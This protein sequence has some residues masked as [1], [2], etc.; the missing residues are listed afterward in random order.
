MKNY[1]KISSEIKK[2]AERYAVQLRSTQEEIA[3]LVMEI[4]DLEDRQ[5]SQINRKISDIIS[6][7]AAQTQFEGGD[8]DVNLS[9]N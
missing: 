2:G 8:Q 4:V 7:S 3:K 5:A 9:Q 6:R 1:D